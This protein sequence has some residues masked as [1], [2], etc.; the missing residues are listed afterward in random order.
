MEEGFST[1]N[2]PFKPFTFTIVFSSLT[3][4]TAECN[5]IIIIAAAAAAGEKKKIKFRRV[6]HFSFWR[7][8]L[9]G[10]VLAPPSA[11][12]ECNTIIII[13]IAAAAAA[14]GEKKKR[15]FFCVRHFSFL[16]IFLPLLCP[17]H[18]SFPRYVQ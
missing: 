16:K 6:R 4:A 3:A 12:A 10:C 7:F 13:V 14:A 17:C 8:S 11:T 1:T 18:P 15:K 2:I 9:L 5:T